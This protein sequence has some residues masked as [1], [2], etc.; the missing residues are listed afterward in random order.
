[1]DTNLFWLVALL[2]V[3]C[4]VYMSVN[5]TPADMS[6]CLFQLVNHRTGI[7]EI[8]LRVRCEVL[9][10]VTEDFWYMILCNLVNIY[11]LFYPEDGGNM[12]FWNVSKY[13]QWSKFGPLKLR[14]LHW[15][16]IFGS[17]SLL[18][19]VI[20]QKNRSLLESSL[21]CFADKQWNKLMAALHCIYC[22]R[23]IVMTCHHS[24]C[25]SFS[26]YLCSS[27]V[28]F[29]LTFLLVGVGRDSVVSVVTRYG[30]DSSGDRI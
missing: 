26:F 10:V 7:D 6:V 24:A 28:F 19:S 25:A 3:L 29:S 9:M 27:S 20:S 21:F 4:T 11:W 18:L 30:L 8:C 5:W 17:S 16:K 22:C 14:T 2:C 1:M 12:F 23:Y 13:P 15:L